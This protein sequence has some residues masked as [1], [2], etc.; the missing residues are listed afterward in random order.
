MDKKWT[1][2]C[3]NFSLTKFS[4]FATQN[5]GDPRKH[6][7]QINKKKDQNFGPSFR[8]AKAAVNRTRSRAMTIAM[9]GMINHEHDTS[10][11]WLVSA[12]FG[13]GP[14]LSH[15]L[16]Q[17]AGRITSFFFSRLFQGSSLPSLCVDHVCALFRDYIEFD[18][19]QR[20]VSPHF[21]FDPSQSSRLWLIGW[22]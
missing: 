12:C 9:I 15:V 16:T 20:T 3:T 18:P 21:I 2:F 17:G 4:F 1:L 10:G 5:L 11:S 19:F 13:L 22:D 14:L 7:G 8:C 6:F